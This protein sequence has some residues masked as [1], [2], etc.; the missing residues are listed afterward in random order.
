[1]CGMFS[2][3]ALQ[4]SGLEKAQKGLKIVFFCHVMCLSISHLMYISL[5][6]RQFFGSTLRSLTPLQWIHN[7][8]KPI[9][10]LQK[11]RFFDFNYEK[12]ILMAILAAL[13][14]ITWGNGAFYEGLCRSAHIAELPWHGYVCQEEPVS[15]G[16]PLSHE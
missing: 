11:S 12:L 14:Q 1:M 4:S 6:L 13:Q 3:P 9:F 5:L 2:I 16:Q 8:Q 7:I 10:Y 15:Q